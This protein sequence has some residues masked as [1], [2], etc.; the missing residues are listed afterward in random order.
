M[1]ESGQTRPSGNPACTTRGFFLS[2][3]LLF[4]VI[5][6][7]AQTA[8][9]SLRMVGSDVLG[10]PVVTV[11][12]SHA[13]GFEQRLELQFSG[14]RPAIDRIEAGVAD[15]AVLVDYPEA[16]AL[17]AGWMSVPLGYLTAFI[18]VPERLP[19]EQ[20]AI[21]DL[22]KAF[23]A[24]SPVPN[25][26]WGDLGGRGEWAGI[27]VRPMLTRPE[28]GLGEPL[29]RHIVLADGAYRSGVSWHDTAEAAL[30]VARREEGA[31]LVVSRPPAPGSGLKVLRVAGSDGRGGFVPTAENLQSGNYPMGLALRL[32]FPRKQA[33]ERLTWLR[34]WHGTA[35]SEALEACGVVPLPVAVRN[36]QVFDLELLD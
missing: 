12:E 33:I 18:V 34:L 14:S 21:A 3:L 19:I 9:P 32:A 30:A 8:S 35:M 6:S 13:A 10:Q 27:A 4:G 16:P 31:L 11:L 2:G 24:D 36:Q 23:S 7:K 1:A 29:F 20:V 5:G 26:R 22:F 15:L 25:L 17:P 28:D